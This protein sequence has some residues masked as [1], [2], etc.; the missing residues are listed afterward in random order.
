MFSC[1][2]EVVAKTA[3][4]LAGHD[5]DNARRLVEVYQAR[6][7]SDK[8]N[9]LLGASE[10]ILLNARIHA[11]YRRGVMAVL[12]SL[13]LK[14]LKT[15]MPVLIRSRYVHTSNN[16]YYNDLIRVVA[17]A[18]KSVYI[19]LAS[20]YAESPTRQSPEPSEGQARLDSCGAPFLLDAHKCPLHI[21]SIASCC[22]ARLL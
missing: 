5:V 15:S 16:K 22:C 18:I 7:T 20:C 11:E 17:Y 8:L 12:S 14:F 2:D 21:S 9:H 10:E 1:M 13:P 6:H 4:I 3:S 19:S